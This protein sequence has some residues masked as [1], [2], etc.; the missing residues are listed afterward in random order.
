M[1]TISGSNRGVQ[2]YLRAAYILLHT[3]AHGLSDFMVSCL[4]FGLK[5]TMNP[6][7][8]DIKA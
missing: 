5:I 2:Y 6:A 3:L 1:Q 7:G 4:G 8:W